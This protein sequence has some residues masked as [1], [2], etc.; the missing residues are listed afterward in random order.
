MPRC[1]GSGDL[2]PKAQFPSAHPELEGDG[3]E[4]GVPDSVSED[5]GRGQG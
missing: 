5:L 2:L 4:P 3:L 1:W